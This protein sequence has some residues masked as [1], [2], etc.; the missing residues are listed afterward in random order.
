MIIA[1]NR[2]EDHDPLN[3]DPFSNE[4]PQDFLTVCG[5]GIDGIPT[6]EVKFVKGGRGCRHHS[7]SVSSSKWAEGQKEWIAV[8][9]HDSDEIIVF[10]R[11]S[12][13]EGGLKEVV[14]LQGV[15]KPAV[16]V[17]Y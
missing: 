6:G 10:E 17:W 9:S 15:G 12:W 2:A 7:S 14:R 13:E 3:A 11:K 8:A 16:V 1:S 4:I 5:V